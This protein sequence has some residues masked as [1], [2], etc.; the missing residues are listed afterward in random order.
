M[1]RRAIPVLLLLAG[2]SA[3]CS[4]EGQRPLRA[5]WILFETLAATSDL[6]APFD[7]RILEDRRRRGIAI[8]PND[9]PLPDSLGAM[10]AREGARI[11]VV[12]RWLRAISVDADRAVLRRIATHPAVREIRPVGG[13]LAAD[14]GGAADS[15]VSTFAGDTGKGSDSYAVQQQAFDSAF[16]GPNWPVLRELGIPSVHQ[17]GFTGSGI[18]IALLDTG[19]DPRHPA[20]SGRILF[21]VRDFIENDDIVF[22]PPGVAGPSRHGTRVWSLLGGFRPGLIVGPAYDAQFLLAKVDVE[23]GDT[24]ADEDRW[25]AGF[26]WADANGARVIHSSVVFRWDFT[27]R[28]PIPY[29]ELDGDT[30]ITTRIA[31]EAVRRGIVV[32]TAIGDGGPAAG[33][34]SSP[35][36]ADSVISVG[37]VDALGQAATFLNGASGRGPTA[38]GRIKPEVS[39]RGVGLVAAD[40]GAITGYTAGLAGTSYSAPLISGAVGT[41]LEAWPNLGPMAV[42]TALLLAGRNA[43]N[44]NNAVGVGVPDV[45]GA[46]LFPEGIHASSVTPIDLQGTLASIGPRFTWNAPLVQPAMRPILYRV[47]I[48]S[49]P[50]FDRIVQSDT[51][52]EVFTLDV[53]QP[54]RPA[55]ALW[56]RVVATT[57]LGVRYSSAVSGPFRVPSWVRLISPAP[58]AVTFVETP[59]PTLTWAPIEAP[60]PLGPFTYDVEILSSENGQLVQPTIRNLSTSQLRVP[61][62]LVA[63]LAYRWRVIAR[64]AAGPADTVESA[65]PFVVT[66]SA[67]PPATLLYQNF[68]NPFPGP[69]SGST[70]I[71]FDLAEESAV[72]LSVFDLRAGLVR[73][74]IPAEESCGTVRLPAGQYGRGPPDQATDPCIAL[75]WNGRDANGRIVPRGVYVLRMRVNGKV[76]YRRMVFLPPGG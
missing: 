3:G 15:S 39:A 54:L 58:G 68:P 55:P 57:P 71:W 41:F 60:Q 45:A 63:N 67:R 24:Q 43:V 37:A 72:E 1:I 53:R 31:D 25:V 28:P 11:R 10:L 12:S 18:R 20:L 51:A 42:R 50:V 76:E 7:E 9:R 36:D 61:Q 40:P 5:Y 35:A 23:P 4:D 19:F 29:A 49:D 26:E 33:S 46:I 52:R 8:Y 13:L 44:R 2:V 65:S 14:G 74:L 48:A 47:E 66:S 17:V 56:W 21:R 16:Y 59:Q 27:D 62:P 69:A 75:A 34:L 64:T 70:R 22:D 6:P 38:D 73:R 32:V 30:R